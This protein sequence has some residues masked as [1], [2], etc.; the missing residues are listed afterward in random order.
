M[1]NVIVVPAVKEQLDEVVKQHKN[2][3]TKLQKEFKTQQN[4]EGY[5][6]AS[7]LGWQLYESNTHVMENFD[8]EVGYYWEGSVVDYINYLQDEIDNYQ[9][10]VK[11]AKFRFRHNYYDI[12]KRFHLTEENATSVASM[13]FAGSLKD[14]WS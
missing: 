2:L 11:E 10:L 9:T 6:V 12:T 4:A 13:Y 3:F 8:Q 5:F 14:H 1:E 7:L